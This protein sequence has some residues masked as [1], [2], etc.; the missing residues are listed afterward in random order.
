MLRFAAAA[1]LLLS[2]TAFAQPPSPADVQKL[3]QVALDADARW[4]ARDAEGMAALYDEQASMRFQGREATIESRAAVREYFTA[5]FAQLEPGL[6]HRS[7]VLQLTMQSDDVVLADNA[8]RVLRPAADGGSTTLREFSTVT[9]LA[10]QAD[11]SW[12][13]RGIRVFPLA[14][15]AE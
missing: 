8:V 4:N 15:A 13:I 9:V 5:S 2:S 10:R 14:L 6:V 12:K 1:M 7:D 11:G 3:M